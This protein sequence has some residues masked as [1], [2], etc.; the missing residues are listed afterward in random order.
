MNFCTIQLPS[1]QTEKER[2]SNT[3]CKNGNHNKNYRD[4]KIVLKNKT[5]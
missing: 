5:N 2:V 3:I 1:I 4:K